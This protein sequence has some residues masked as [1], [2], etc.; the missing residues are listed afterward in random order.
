MQVI[1][2]VALAFWPL[3]LALGATVVVSWIERRSTRG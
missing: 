2:A 1:L 3:W